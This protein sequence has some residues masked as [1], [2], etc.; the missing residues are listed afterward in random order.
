MPN[1][2]IWPDGFTFSA[3]ANKHYEVMIRNGYGSV[4]IYSISSS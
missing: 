2:V 1:G 3:E 4:L